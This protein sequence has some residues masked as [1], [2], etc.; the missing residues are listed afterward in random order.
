L[1]AILLLIK[2]LLTIIIGSYFHEVLVTIIALH[3]HIITLPTDDTP[4]SLRITDD[5]KYARYFTDCLGALDRTHIDVHVPTTDQPRYRN[6]K[7]TL[8]QNVLGVYNFEIQFTYV[9]AG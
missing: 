7:G 2:H 3:R 9:L 8:T 1:P 6:R 4:P 5:T